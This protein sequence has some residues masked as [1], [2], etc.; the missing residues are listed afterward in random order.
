MN[1]EICFQ[2]DKKIAF[3]REV[4]T[5]NGI[6]RAWDVL[7]EFIN[8]SKPLITEEAEYLGVCYD[9]P[10]RDD[11]SRE[12]MRYDA[13]VTV[14]SQA[15]ATKEVSVGTL[16]GGKYAVFL[17]EGPLS[18]LENTWRSIYTEWLPS[19]GERL[20]DVPPYERYNTCPA[21]TSPMNLRTAIYIPLE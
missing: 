7:D 10:K 11:V 2:S 14:V 1:P 4:D 9:M 15:Q 19:S 18:E 16:S 6:G 3:V 20:R 12:E 21:E 13:A 8:T 17:H 5:L